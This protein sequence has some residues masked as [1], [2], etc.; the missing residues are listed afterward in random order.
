MKG[1]HMVLM[2]QIHLKAHLCSTLDTHMNM[3]RDILSFCSTTWDC[4]GSASVETKCSKRR[5]EKNRRHR[6]AVPILMLSEESYL[7]DIREK[8]TWKSPSISI[9]GNTNEK[10]SPSTCHEVSNTASHFA[11]FLTD[12]ISSIVT[13]FAAVKNICLFFFLGITFDFE[14]HPLVDILLNVHSDTMD[15]WKYRAVTYKLFKTHR[16][17]SLCVSVCMG[18]VP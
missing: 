9:I 7:A 10:N 8:G 1:S 6:C 2:P 16:F 17:I 3:G 13:M 15:A 4:G 18:S 12:K 11:S 14:W 5:E